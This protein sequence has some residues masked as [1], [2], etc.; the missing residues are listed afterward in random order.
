MG[1]KF[2]KRV[3]FL[4]KRHCQQKQIL[5]VMQQFQILVDMIE[6]YFA[7]DRPVS[8]KSFILLIY[9]DSINFLANANSF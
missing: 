3:L 4:L 2:K 6:F 1:V 5:A 9:F 8:Q 7:Q